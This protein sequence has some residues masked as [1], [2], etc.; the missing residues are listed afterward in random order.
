[1]V[2]G[3]GEV[4][5]VTMT[6][7]EY[8]DERHELSDDPEWSEDAWYVVDHNGIVAGPFDDEGEAMWWGDKAKR[9]A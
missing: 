7:E 4:G 2:L 6:S 8:I 3:D 9:V 5:R 1:M